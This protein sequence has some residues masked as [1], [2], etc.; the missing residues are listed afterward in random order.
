[1]LSPEL[2][3]VDEQLASVA[4]ER[5]ETP[6]L[7]AL[8][9]VSVAQ[10]GRQPA[11]A[12]RGLTRRRRGSRAVVAGCALVV[13]CAL[14]GGVAENPMSPRQ[15][16]GSTVAKEPGLPVIRWREAAGADVYNVILYEG[17]RRLDFWPSANRMELV[18]SDGRHRV[19]PG[20][21]AWFVY[22]GFREG[23]TTRYGP[24]LAHGK[25]DVR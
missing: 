16:P 12:P 17:D 10:A 25:L 22:A 20:S 8:P 14:P 11:A 24:L 23:A 9:R 3:L 2:A 13:L 21:Y 1:M 6:S 5:M 18:T 19:R 15:T 7:L 4:R